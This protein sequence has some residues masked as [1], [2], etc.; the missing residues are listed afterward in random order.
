MEVLA[1]VVT[2]C[3]VARVE[4]HAVG[5]FKLIVAVRSVACPKSSPHRTTSPSWLTC[6]VLQHSASR[7]QT[8]WPLHRLRVET[9]ALALWESRIGVAKL[10]CS[11]VNVA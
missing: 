11:A 5:V 6:L 2:S 10:L 8:L 3:V 4:L 9:L 1:R 7:L